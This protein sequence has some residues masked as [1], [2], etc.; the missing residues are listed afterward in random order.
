M[1]VRSLK[2]D[3][4]WVGSPAD[5]YCLLRLPAR[6]EARSWTSR[7]NSEARPLPTAQPAPNP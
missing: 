3:P 4:F 7:Q 6:V 2:D 1:L 5:P